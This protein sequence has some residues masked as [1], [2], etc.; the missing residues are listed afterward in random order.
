MTVN[1]IVIH[2]YEHIF[3]AILDDTL[4]YIPRSG[5]QKWDQMCD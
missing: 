2:I 4:V 5:G 3:L 1:D